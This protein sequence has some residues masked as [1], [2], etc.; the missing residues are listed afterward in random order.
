MIGFMLNPQTNDIESVGGKIKLLSTVQEAIR[1]KLSIKLRTFAGEYFLDTTYGVP[2][3][4]LNGIIGGKKSKAE[5]DAIF[6]SIINDEPEVQRII[7]FDSTY[8]AINRRYD[9]NFDVRVADRALRPQSPELTP[10]EEITYEFNDTALTPACASDYMTYSV[11]L[12][13]TV[14][15]YIPM[16]PTFGWIGDLDYGINDTNL[17]GA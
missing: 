4:G 16:G 14:H 10:S 13:E 1:Q 5:V 17:S 9:L 15:Y 8:N 6:I 12:H 3:R 11:D 2:Y 7:S